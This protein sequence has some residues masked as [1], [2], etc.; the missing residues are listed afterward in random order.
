MKHLYRI[1]LLLLL[2]LLF[3]TG[4]SQK[5]VR[6][7]LRIAPNIAWMNP[8]Q[9]DYSYNGVGAG[10]S[11]GFVSDFYFTPNY[12]LST[13]FTFS[14]LN[15]NLT[16]PFATATDTGTVNRKYNF[17]YLEIPL[18]VKMKTKEFGRFSFYAQIG[19][20]TGFRLKCEAKDE[21]LTQEHGT[22]ND[23]SNITD[24]E[25]TLIREA[26]LV[27]I[28][29]EVRLDESVSLMVGLS[30]S[31]TLNNVLKGNNSRYPDLTNR[32]SLNFAELSVG[33]LF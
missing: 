18:M 5:K 2:V 9:K 7:G 29:T 11:L 23:K 28:G 31:N 20:G 1:L 30:Y 14:F 13:G 12:G 24:A 17:R 33:V 6:L 26:I 10:V 8:D 19:F 4:Y 25:T 27:G 21:F 3:S 22:I 32:S 15:G 16:Q